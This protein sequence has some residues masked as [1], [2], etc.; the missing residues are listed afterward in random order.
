M[1]T[2][3]QGAVDKYSWIPDTFPGEGGALM[4]NDNYK[5]KPAYYAVLDTLYSNRWWH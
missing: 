4:W 1:L 5:K 3:R 2:V